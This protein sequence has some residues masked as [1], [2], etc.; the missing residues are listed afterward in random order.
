MVE[1]RTCQA[2]RILYKKYG[3]KNKVRCLVVLQLV[4]LTVLVL[5]IV[6]EN[7]GASSIFTRLT[8]SAD[9]AVAGI[10]GIV[11]AVMAAVA[12]LKLLF[13]AGTAGSVSRG[14]VIYDQASN[15]KDQL[16]FMDHVKVKDTD[17]CLCL[18][19]APNPAP[20]PKVP[21]HRVN[22]FLR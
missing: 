21:H 1:W 18:K 20:I 13:E 11:A 8:S 22:L 10:A 6:L 9:A 12:P 3:G 2:T 16:G 14:Q 4:I 19:A 7:V 17:Q 5:L 15:V